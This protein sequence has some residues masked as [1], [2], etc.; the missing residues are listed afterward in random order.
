MLT[1]YFQATVLQKRGPFRPTNTGLRNY[2][3]G[4]C[5]SMIYKEEMNGR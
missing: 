3:G 1:L 4:L 5:S 2:R